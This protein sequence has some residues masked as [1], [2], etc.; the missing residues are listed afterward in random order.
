MEIRGIG[1][2]IGP[3]EY[4]RQSAEQAAKP[5]ERMIEDTLQISE[6]A[7]KLFQ[8]KGAGGAPSGVDLGRRIEALQE[9]LVD[10]L[11]ASGFAKDAKEASGLAKQIAERVV[12]LETPE[13]NRLDDVRARIESG[14][15]SGQEVVGK[16]AEKLMRD[17]G[18]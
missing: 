16:V 1:S 11:T 6:E 14:H 2:G 17:M 18:L 15:Y 4:Q 9:K 10:K 5:A 12:E 3:Q 8:E 13:R 7:R